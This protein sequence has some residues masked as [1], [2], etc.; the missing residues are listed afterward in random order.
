MT[1]E[2]SKGVTWKKSLDEV[3]NDELRLTKQSKIG[4]GQ[5]SVDLLWT[6]N[7]AG[8]GTEGVTRIGKTGSVVK[9]QLGPDCERPAHQMTV[10]ALAVVGIV[11]IGA[12]KGFELG[13]HRILSPTFPLTKTFLRGSKEV[14]NTRHQEIL[15]TEH[16]KYRLYKGSDGSAGNQWSQ[17]R[18]QIPEGGGRMVK[19]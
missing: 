17:K 10:L 7:T 4:K 12:L 19:E 2:S 11:A 6:R 8:A 9:R 3:L 13:F 16:T 14:G 1:L 15:N 5:S 18:R